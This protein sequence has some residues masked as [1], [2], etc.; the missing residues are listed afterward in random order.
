MGMGVF[1]FGFCIFK[2]S[3]VK[4]WVLGWM[5]WFVLYLN[6]L[7]FWICGEIRFVFD[8]KYKM[9]FMFVVSVLICVVV[10]WIGS[11]SGFDSGF[12]LELKIWR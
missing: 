9:F 12:V 3:F 8:L 5:G 10:F 6:R 1:N 7:C 2:M 11:I 4:F